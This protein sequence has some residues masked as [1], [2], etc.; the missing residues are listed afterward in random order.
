MHLTPLP[1]PAAVPEALIQDGARHRWLRFAEPLAVVAA[2]SL[3]AVR[4]ALAETVRRVEAEGLWAAGFVSYEAGPAFDEALATR[5]PAAGEED[6]RPPLVWFALYRRVATLDSPLAGIA[7]TCRTGAWR[8]SVDAAGFRA[9]V[10]EIHRLIAL[11][12]TYQVNFTHRLRAPFAGDPRALFRDL[13]RAQ[14]GGSAAYLDTGRWAVC[15]AS[16]E[17]F[18][19]LDGERVT[20]R[21]MKGTARRGL[22]AADDRERAR[23]LAASAKERAENLMI[24]DMVRNDLGRVAQPGSVRVPEL[25]AVERY[26]TVL[27]MTSTVRAETDAPVDEL[28]AALFPCASITGAPKPR[29][30]EIIARLEDGPRGV[31][32]GAVGYLAP[33]RRA[34]FNVAI[35]TAVVDRHRGSAEYG[36]GGGIVWDSRAAAELAECRLKARVLAAVAGAAE[37][38]PGSAPWPD[39]ELLETLR[40]DPVRGYAL[41]AEHLV[42]LAASAEYFA[43]PLDPGAVDAE[44]DRLAARAA[45]A[46]EVALRVRL[47]VDERGRVRGEATPLG[48]AGAPFGPAEPGDDPAAS[49]PGVGALA[50]GRPLRLGLASDPIDPDDPFLY[51]KT[52]HRTVYDRALSARPDC[53]EVLLYNPAGEATEATIANL[54]V[55]RGGELL[56]PPLRCGL[57]AGTLR[58]RL[59]AEGRIRE[60]VLRVDE[61]A[62]CAELW[63]INSVRGWRRAELAEPA[64]AGRVAPR[65]RTAPIASR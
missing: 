51:H 3:A 17:L 52:T 55:R 40:W 32:T 16:P 8:P 53:D 7:G 22:A 23:R 57:L 18:F 49:D 1:D 63:L 9:A 2:R 15:S 33:G 20:A 25:F 42:R 12:E 61:L 21:P 48:A 29:T 10:A 26:P 27:Q 14:L 5:T 36:V 34:R 41:R 59:L 28:F 39:F 54:V 47:L 31:Y 46:P 60:A 11:G 50:G 62:D 13:A 65:R 35:R 19:E 24:V 45:A 30:S 37:A 64:A 4:P 56:T 6:D 58:A 44:L 43:V 38:A